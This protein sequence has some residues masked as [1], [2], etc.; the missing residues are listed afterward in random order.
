MAPEENLKLLAVVQD[1]VWGRMQYGVRRSVKD[2]QINVQPGDVVLLVHYHRQRLPEVVV[3]PGKATSLDYHPGNILV[4]RRKVSGHDQ[5]LYQCNLFS[6]IT[7]KELMVENAK[8]MLARGSDPREF[9]ELLER[10]VIEKAR[11]GDYT[12]EDVRGWDKY[13]KLRARFMHP[14]TPAPEADVAKRLGAAILPKIC[15]GQQNGNGGQGK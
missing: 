1:N 11:K 2:V 3:I 6:I 5:V 8:G 4:G 14:T 12:Q 9:L 10:I 15:F 13:L 7:N